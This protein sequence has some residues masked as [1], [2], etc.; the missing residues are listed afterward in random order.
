VAV[1]VASA[2]ARDTC[3]DLLAHVRAGPSLAVAVAALVPTPP[4]PHTLLNLLLANLL[5][6]PRLGVLRGLV[7][8]VGLLLLCD[9]G[10]GLTEDVV[11][12]GGVV[13][14]AGLASPVV[15]DDGF[16]GV[17]SPDTSNSSTLHRIT[18]LSHVPLSHLSQIHPEASTSI[19]SPLH[20]T[21]RTHNHQL[22]C[23]ISQDKSQ[24]DLHPTIAA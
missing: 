19:A 4:M 5:A 13:T 20:P 14:A 10:T 8:A 23:Y 12:G 3:L 17:R 6:S 7:T 11:L 9:D 15:D 21:L 16:T 22:S 18:S 2:L 1:D 24:L